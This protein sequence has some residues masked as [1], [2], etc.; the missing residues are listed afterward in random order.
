MSPED[1]DAANSPSLSNGC[2]SNGATFSDC[3]QTDENL[4]SSPT[5]SGSIES[6]DRKVFGW[7]GFQ[8]KC[9]QNLL[10]A[11]WALF[12]MCWAGALQGKKRNKNYY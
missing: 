5:V 10:S 2:K 1:L 4:I 8:P 6:D 7:C 3:E 12:W 9:L 11:K